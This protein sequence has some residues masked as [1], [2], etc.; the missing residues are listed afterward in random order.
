MIVSRYDPETLERMQ[1]LQSQ[2]GVVAAEAR[3]RRVARSR[4]A[5]SQQAEAE[6]SDTEVDVE[7]QASAVVQATEA[8][9]ADDPTT[10]LDGGEHTDVEAAE[11]VGDGI[12]AS[13]GAET[14]DGGAEAGDEEPGKSTGGN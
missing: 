4:A 10:D 12:E 7:A 11:E 6:G 13:E 14:E 3:R 8:A 1:A 2:R 9:L 5:A